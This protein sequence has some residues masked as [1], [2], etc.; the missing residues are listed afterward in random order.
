MPGYRRSE[1]QLVH[2]SPL[3]VS[4]RLRKRPTFGIKASAIHLPVRLASFPGVATHNLYPLIL[5]GVLARFF[6]Q[7]SVELCIERQP[8]DGRA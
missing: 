7:V 8:A 6:Q 5:P 1:T 2:L 4:H 3:A